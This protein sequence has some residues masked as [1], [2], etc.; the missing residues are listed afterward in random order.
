MRRDVGMYG[1][2]TVRASTS[3]HSMILATTKTSLHLSWVLHKAR[4]VTP[5]RSLIPNHVDNIAVDH[6]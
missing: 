6:V 5:L 3:L 2:K 1:L 4:K